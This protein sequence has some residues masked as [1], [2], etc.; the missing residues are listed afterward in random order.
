MCQF[1]TGSAL[2]ITLFKK[3]NINRKLTV[4]ECLKRVTPSGHIFHTRIP[5]LVR[6][7]TP[8]QRATAITTSLYYQY[9]E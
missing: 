9:F 6:I 5:H 1:K 4:H 7:L 8:A 2:S 3:M